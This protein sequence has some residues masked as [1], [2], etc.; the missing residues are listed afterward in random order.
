MILVISATTMP[1]NTTAS[2]TGPK[3]TPIPLAEGLLSGIDI[4]LFIN[5]FVFL[6]SIWS[7]FFIFSIFVLSSAAVMCIV[8]QLQGH[9]IWVSGFLL[10]ARIT[11]RVCCVV[12]TSNIFRCWTGCVVDFSGCRRCGVSHVVGFS[13]FDWWWLDGCSVPIWTFIGNCIVYSWK[14]PLKIVHETK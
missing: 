5:R 6:L 10:E 9:S 12:Y 11:N 4:Y 8:P 13:C 1:P 3:A 7:S 14:C 2:K